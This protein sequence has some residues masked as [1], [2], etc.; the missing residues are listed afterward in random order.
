MICGEEPKTT[1]SSEIFVM[2]SQEIQRLARGSESFS[3][4]KYMMFRR[5]GELV[6]MRYVVKYKKEIGVLDKLK[7][8]Y[9]DYITWYL[10]NGKEG[11]YQ[12]IFYIHNENYCSGRLFGVSR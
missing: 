4:T 10:D 2:F 11:L 7:A 1:S 6:Y 8:V 12:R 5:L 3:F 9:K